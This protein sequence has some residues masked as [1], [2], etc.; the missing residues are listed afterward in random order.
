MIVERDISPYR[1]N[2]GWEVPIIQG[3]DLIISPT[4]QQIQNIFTANKDAIHILGGIRTGKMMTMALAEGA[5]RHA[6]MGSLSEPYDRTGIKGRLRDI[7]YR[8]L[9]MFYYRHIDFFLAVGKEGVNT[10][11]RLGFNPNRVFPWAYFVSMPASNVKHKKE[12]EVKKLVYAGRIED[13]KGIYRFVI[14]LANTHMHNYTLDIYGAGPDEEKLRQFIK[15]NQLTGNINVFPFIKY[16]EMA[17]KYAQYDWVILPSTHKEGWGVIVSEG[18]LNGLKTICSDICGVSWAI[19]N[20]FNGVTFDWNTEG[21]CKRAIETMLSS[22]N[23]A[24][25][26]EI[27]D[28]ALKSLS[29]EAGADYYLEILDSTYNG[30]PMP[31]PPWVKTNL[32]LH[33]R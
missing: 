32:N 7:K 5:K 4:R 26:N 33:G 19:I 12:G 20:N 2:M 30:K 13:K 15:D 21:S 16:D 14:E 27:Q 8:Y 24:P 31:T 18:L 29:A 23:F 1:A 25:S 28:L 3:I 22:T 6:K 9:R 17:R 10:Y 11:T